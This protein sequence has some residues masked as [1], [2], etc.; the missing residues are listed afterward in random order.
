MSRLFLKCSL[1][2]KPTL[3]VK[4]PEL[5]LKW[6]KTTNRKEA[7]K[8]VEGNKSV[9]NLYHLTTNLLVL[10]LGMLLPAR[11]RF[12]NLDITSFWQY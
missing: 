4:K 6:N 8:Y 11:F 9:N 2:L 12:R 7:V 10:L 5:N 3:K 1:D